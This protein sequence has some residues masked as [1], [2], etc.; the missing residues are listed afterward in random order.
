MR[1]S[2]A[3]SGVP[4]AAVLGSLECQGAAGP[5][6]A[7]LHLAG[8]CLPG[9]LPERAQLSAGQWRGTGC[10]QRGA[11]CV[12]VLSQPPLSE[13]RGKERLGPRILTCPGCPEGLPGLR[14]H[15]SWNTFPPLPPPQDQ[16]APAFTAAHLAVHAESHGPLCPG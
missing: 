14:V 3:W 5:L 1:D 7:G 9:R 4:K 11:L 2:G 10:V 16:Q 8:S 12:W 6:A 15:E 13:L